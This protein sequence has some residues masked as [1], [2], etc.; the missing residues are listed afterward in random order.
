MAIDYVRIG[1]APLDETALHPMVRMRDG[2][3]LATD[4]YLAGDEAAE[5]VLVRL[6]YDKVGDY[7]FIP[8]IARYFVDHGYHVVAQDVRGKFRSEGESLIF[9]NEAADGFDTL[10]WI[11]QQ[12]W[13]NGVV[14]MFGDSYYG[15]TQWAAASTNHPALRAIS[16]RVTGTR[17]GERPDDRDG[18]VTRDVEMAVHLLYLC[19]FFHSNDVYMW[20]PDWSHRPLIDEVEAFF[21]A[22]GSRSISFDQWYPEQVRLGRF[23][24]GHPFDAKPIPVLM[25]IGWW[26]NCA[27]WQWSDHWLLQGKQGWAHNEFL[28][29]DSV[30]HENNHLRFA[31][32]GERTPDEVEAQLPA[33]LDPTIEFFD[34]F[35]RNRKSAASIPKVR[36]NLAHTEGFRESATW[37]PAGTV[38]QTLY[39]SA[40]GNL[41]ADAS[42]DEKTVTWVHDPDNLVPS[43]VT[44]SFAFLGEYPDERIWSQRD[45]VVVFEGTRV[46][47]D[48]DLVGAVKFSAQVASDGPRMDLFVR[49]LDVDP[50]GAAHLLARGQVH[51]KDSVQ[52]QRIEVDLG[53][54][55]YRLRAGHRLRLHIASSDY[56]EFIPQPGTGGDP[57]QASKVCPNTQS[58]TVGGT[59]GAVLILSTLARS[60]AGYGPSTTPSQS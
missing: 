20:M 33:Y 10:D 40:D 42:A 47:E 17:L 43:P 5:T 19:T 28:L 49:V 54:V 27:P 38:A 15:Y 56:P 32:R 24:F 26:D 8:L 4:V 39:L 18:D 21:A 12:P 22:V 29:I 23:P 13:S 59:G 34:A 51:V 1:P 57:W 48:A 11:V 3:R 16:P 6:P 45:D 60:R 14:G 9:V 7:T 44:N 41:Q 2:V 50:E 30:D 52:P 58:M 31:G 35:L 55:G 53:Q 37:P 46:H 25:T 36:W